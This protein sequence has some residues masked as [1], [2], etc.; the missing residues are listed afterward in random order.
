VDGRAVGTVASRAGLTGDVH[1]V[2]TGKDGAGRS[3]PAG[4][5][6][7]QI[8]AIGSDGEVVRV[9]QPFALVR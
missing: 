2:W 1:L 8:R 5:Y 3:V 4:T 6:L 7:M 9:I